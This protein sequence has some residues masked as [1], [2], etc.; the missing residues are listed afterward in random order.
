MKNWFMVIQI[1]PKS[2]PYSQFNNMSEQVDIMDREKIGRQ[3]ITWGNDD[4]IRWHI[5]MY[6]S[7]DLDN[8]SLWINMYLYV[9]D[10]WL[11]LF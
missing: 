8:L 5:Y 6:A 1:S 3:S 4:Q 10:C 2:R 11:H 7:P 9:S